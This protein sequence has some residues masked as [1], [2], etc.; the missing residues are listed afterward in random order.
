MKK[1]L[2]TMLLAGV[3][4]VAACG[5]T[6]YSAGGSKTKLESN[7]YSVSLYGYEDGK[8]AIEG[9]NYDTVAFDNAIVAT[10]GSGDSKDVFLAF[11]FS[12]VEA[13]STFMSAHENDNTAL[14]YRFAELNLG[15]NF[16][17]KMGTHNNVAWAGSQNAF[18]SAI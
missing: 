10:K 6:M 3:L 5:A 7:G 12:S 11:Y 13:A 17:P 9:P 2:A 15:S 8:K 18:N 4:S 16:Q 14:L 1:L